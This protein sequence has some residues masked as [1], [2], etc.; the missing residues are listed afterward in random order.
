MP[1]SVAVEPNLGWGAER[2]LTVCVKKKKRIA[3]FL[4]NSPLLCSLQAL[5]VLS[6]YFRVGARDELQECARLE[7]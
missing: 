7:L 6:L 3:L 2:S 1:L 4:G 5:E